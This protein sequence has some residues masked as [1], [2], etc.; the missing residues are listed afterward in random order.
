MFEKKFINT[1]PLKIIPL[2]GVEG[3]GINCTV[4]EYRDTIVIVDMGLGFPE[5]DLYGIDYVI[6][7]I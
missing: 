5:G 2:G 3:I 6:Q 7:N 1:N 4:I